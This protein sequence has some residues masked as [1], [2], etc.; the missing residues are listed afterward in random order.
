ML[1]LDHCIFSL[2]NAGGISR[3]WFDHTK[4]MASRFENRVSHVGLH[5]NGNVHLQAEETLGVYPTGRLSPLWPFRPVSIPLGTRVFHSSYFRRCAPQPGVALVFTFHDDVLLN[6]RSVSS[7]L[8]RRCVEA[9]V[10]AASIVHCVSEFSK[11]TL[12]RRYPWFPESRA[13]VIYHGFSMSKDAVPVTQVSDLG[14]PYVL[15]VGNRFGYKNGAISF[16]AL[17]KVPSLHLVVVGGERPSRVEREDL[18]RLNLEARVHFLGG[19]PGP[20]LNWLYQNAVALWYPSL[21]EGFGMPV[22]EAAAQGCPVLACAGHAVEEIGR[23]WPLLSPRPNSTWLAD[24]SL[25]LLSD[26]ALLSRLRSEGPALAA[27]YSWTRY[28]DAMAS[29]YEEA[30]LREMTTCP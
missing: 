26:A 16:T 5:R 11:T 29:L 28:A 13:R 9:C 8:K 15:W 4:C 10:R 18:R 12:L 24:Q 23:G 7:L 3:W 25:R 20:Q 22:I 14:A 21:M 2:Q 27:Q 6:S 1:V 19:L 30:G 17:A